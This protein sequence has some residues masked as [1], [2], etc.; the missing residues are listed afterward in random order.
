MSSPLDTLDIT[1]LRRD[2]N[3][4]P[5]HIFPSNGYTAQQV[6]ASVNLARSL[7]A[8]PRGQ[9]AFTRLCAGTLA[10]TQMETWWGDMTEND[11]AKSF[12]HQVV[13]MFPPI[14]VDCSFAHPDHA[15]C[16]H[17]KAYE[18]D[19]D[20]L[21]HAITISE[22]RLSKMCLAGRM[23]ARE[24]WNSKEKQR[25][26]TFVCKLALTFVHELGHLFVQYLGRGKVDTPPSLSRTGKGHIGEAGARL[27]VEMFGG[28]VV[29]TRNTDEDDD[30]AGELYL[31]DSDNEIRKITQKAMDDF[32]QYNF[33][34]P[35]GTGDVVP[36][37]SV[38]TLG[39]GMPK[40]YD[41]SDPFA[42][43]TAPALIEEH[44]RHGNNSNP[45]RWSEDLKA[46]MKEEKEKDA[47]TTTRSDPKSTIY[48]LP[49][50]PGLAESD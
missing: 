50:E 33:N 4:K 48:Q 23:A 22:P 47:K 21:Q 35:F 15:A 16:T 45:Y 44:K 43:P 37:K 17:R 10:N 20:P 8:G 30:Q 2:K 11:L 49:V 5:D 27:E 36:R 24:P 39:H 34:L 19:F 3:G 1:I 26:R 29:S 13:A 42:W 31:Y 32:V 25:Y 7:I 41:I 46:L 6:M 40:T 38:K 12:I 14:F 18:G 9:P 28:C